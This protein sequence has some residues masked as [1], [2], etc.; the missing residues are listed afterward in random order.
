VL[1]HALPVRELHLPQLQLQGNQRDRAGEG[2]SPAVTVSAASIAAAAASNSVN[3]KRE[4]IDGPAV[5]LIVSLHQEESSTFL[6]S[7]S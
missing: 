3:L 7:V 2:E 5:V 1:V 6:S 4:R